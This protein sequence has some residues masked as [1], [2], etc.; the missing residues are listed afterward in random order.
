MYKEVLGRNMDIPA[1][2]MGLDDYEALDPPEVLGLKT[3][4]LCTR[5]QVLACVL[6]SVQLRSGESLCC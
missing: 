5:Y 4:P 2:S 3:G 6:G 1:K